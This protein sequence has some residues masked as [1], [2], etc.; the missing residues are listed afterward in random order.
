MYQIVNMMNL[1]YMAKPIYGGWVTFTSHL[2]LK[3][4]GDLYKIGKRSEPNTRVYG[5]GVKYRN[6]RIDELITKENILITA[7]DK[8]CYTVTPI[9]TSSS[10]FFIP[11]TVAPFTKV[12]DIVSVLRTI[13][14]ICVLPS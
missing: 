13:S 7:V 11:V 3:Y 14:I 12:P 6:L 4:S 5:Y 2:A 10:S 1:V 9:V 8:H